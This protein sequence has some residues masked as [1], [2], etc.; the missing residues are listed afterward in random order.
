M[1]LDRI[2]IAFGVLIGA[3]TGLLYAFVPAVRAFAIPP[4][5]WVLIALA[6]FEVAVFARGQTPISPGPRIISFLI[7]L[8]LAVL[9]PLALGIEIKLI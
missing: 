4:L 8:S 9:I 7:A 6:L 1:T 2:F 5:F 3:A